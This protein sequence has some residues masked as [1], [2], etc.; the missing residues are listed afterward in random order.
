MCPTVS[1]LDDIITL[2]AYTFGT[3]CFWQAVLFG[4]PVLCLYC[5]PKMVGL[6][7]LSNPSAS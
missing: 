2:W 7:G 6:E 3:F 4:N 5:L 1:C